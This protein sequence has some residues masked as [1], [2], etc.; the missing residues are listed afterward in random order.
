[1]AWI[2]G[3]NASDDAIEE[4]A[5]AVSY[6]AEAHTR[7]AAGKVLSEVMG[8]HKEVQASCKAAGSGSARPVSCCESTPASSRMPACCSV[9]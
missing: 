3:T 7:V 2:A 9:I 6:L 1:M 4:M 5:R 8:L